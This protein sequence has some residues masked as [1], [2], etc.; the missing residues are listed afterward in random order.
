MH[1]QL[2]PS[3]WMWFYLHSQH[4]FLV[5]CLWETA[6]GGPFASKA[7]QNKEW[8]LFFHIQIQRMFA[9]VCG[10]E[11]SITS[12]SLGLFCLSY[13][14]IGRSIPSFNKYFLSGQVPHP[15]LCHKYLVWR[16]LEGAGEITAQGCGHWHYEAK[17]ASQNTSSSLSPGP[18]S[19]LRV[20][21]EALPAL[22]WYQ[23]R[24]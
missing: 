3:K 14:A 10:C 11:S 4:P 2:L 18:A 21:E 5:A 17:D 9:Y 1:I 13:T 19:S 16:V 12:L 20:T 22:H 15:L 24:K 8:P 7:E 23:W 6:L